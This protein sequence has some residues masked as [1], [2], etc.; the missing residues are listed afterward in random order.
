MIFDRYLLKNLIIATLFTAISL[1]AIIML[2]QS[3]R[4]LELIINSGASG[5]SFFA[6]TFLALPRFFE[7]I[8]PIALM[9]GTVFIY[10]KMTADSEMVVM[11]TS[12]FSPF[13]YGEASSYVG[14]CDSCHNLSS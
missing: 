6:L 5:L 13:A 7:V 8:L 14:L 4:F 3:L 10:N 12:G 1:A 11:R 2:T 9:I